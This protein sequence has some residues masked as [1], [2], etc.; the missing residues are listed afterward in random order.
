MPEAYLS[1]EICERKQAC[2]GQLS[3]DADE[4]S[5]LRQLV[6]AGHQE[7]GGRMG[8]HS[9]WLHLPW[10]T[11]QE[12]GEPFPCLLPQGVTAGTPFCQIALRGNPFPS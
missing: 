1:S 6:A 12:D 7:L 5:W 10:V 2:G 3:K 9:H 11:A 8:G 4:T